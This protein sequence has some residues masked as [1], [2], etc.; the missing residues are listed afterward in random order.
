LS[1]NFLKLKFFTAIVLA[2]SIISAAFAMEQKKVVK[3]VLKGNS[4]DYGNAID[5]IK[6]NTPPELP[7]VLKEEY[8]DDDDEDVRMRIISA[9]KL[10]RAE[11][12]APYWIEI[13]KNT[14][15]S[16][17]ETDLIEYLGKSGMFTIPI[18]E[19]LLAPMSD[20]RQKAALA[21]KKSGDDRIL[22]VILRLS[23]SSNPIDR[24]YLLEALNHLYDIRFQKLVISLLSD[25]N[26]SVRIYAIKCVMDNDI[27]EASTAIKRLVADDKNDE[28]RKRGID[29]LVHFKDTGSGAIIAGLL[30]E[31]NRDLSLAAIKALRSLKYGNSAGL[32]SEMLLRENDREIREAVIDALTGFGKAG[33][34]DGLKKTATKDEDPVMRIKAVYALGDVAE[35]KSTMD[36]LALALSDTDYRVRGEACSALGKMRRSRPS[37]LLINQIRK[38]SSRYVRSAALYSLEKINDEK[39]LV[40]L[41]DIYSSENDTVFRDILRA[42]L[43][44]NLVKLVR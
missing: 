27:K 3:A 1:R 31:G 24:I 43:R 14:S 10:Y 28:V 40:P 4:P 33:N 22:P 34:I 35:E 13:F 39:N 16:R 37:E 29:A 44:K 21:L 17:I 25:D 11:N 26:K 5:F 8:L 41:F 15:N 19:K 12:I 38:D 30:K 42:Y 9:L 32:L 20:V 2:I 7:S 23:K 6:E 18:A 36:I